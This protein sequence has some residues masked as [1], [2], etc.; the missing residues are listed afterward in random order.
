ML[1]RVERIS[2]EYVRWFQRDG[3][4]G[5]KR[6]RTEV[7]G[8]FGE[9]AGAAAAE[10]GGLVF[11]FGVDGAVVEMILTDDLAVW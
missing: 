6:R 11:G 8:W 1:R 4:F 2:G 7:F 5:G 9:E 10:D 3:W